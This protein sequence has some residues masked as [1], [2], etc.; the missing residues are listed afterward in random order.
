MD[1]LLMGAIGLLFIAIFVL[2]VQLLE[3][4]DIEKD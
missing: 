2:S 3:K 1:N 4:Q